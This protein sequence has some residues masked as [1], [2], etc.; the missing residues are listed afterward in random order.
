MASRPWRAL[1]KGD[2]QDP[3]DV[4]GVGLR[5]PRNRRQ[6]LRIVAGHPSTSSQDRLFSSVARNVS[7]TLVFEPRRER[8]VTVPDGPDARSLGMFPT[9][10]FATLD[11]S[12]SFAKLHG[13]S[14]V[15]RP[16]GPAGESGDGRYRPAI[17]LV[18]KPMITQAVR[19]RSSCRRGNREMTC[20][21]D[22]KKSQ[23]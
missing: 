1:R 6:G 10:I 4:D 2:G 19:K 14:S 20:T 9:G 7:I 21:C 8:V 13:V 22:E 12:L 16:R 18:S 15:T 3:K 23:C 5:G 11:T 17:L